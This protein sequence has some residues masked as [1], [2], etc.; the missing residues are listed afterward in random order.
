VQQSASALVF[1]SCAHCILF[2]NFCNTQGKYSDQIAS[3]SLCLLRLRTNRN[4]HKQN[5]LPI[6]SGT[7]IF[8]R[9]YPRRFSSDHTMPRNVQSRSS[10]GRQVAKKS[11]AGLASRVLETKRARRPDIHQEDLVVN[12]QRARKSTATRCEPRGAAR[13]K[14]RYKPGELALSDIRKLQNT[15]DMLI[16]KTRF[17]RLVREIT[18]SY[19]SDEPYKY[20]VAALTALQEAAEA[21]LVYLF[22]DTNLCCIHARRVTIMPRDIQLARRIRN[23]KY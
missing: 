22:E 12:R 15:T 19:T 20:Q 17:H 18:Q 3:D 13:R 4:S 21:Y 10:S 11:T 1:F 6:L 2:I 16:P 5:R 9:V 8:I 7:A 23:E 14:I